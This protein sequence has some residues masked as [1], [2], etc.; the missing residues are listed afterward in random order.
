LRGHLK[1][2]GGCNDAEWRLGRYGW[3]FHSAAQWERGV[4]CGENERKI[5]KQQ[6]AEYLRELR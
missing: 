1:R 6:R 3:D 4:Y 5:R 2:R